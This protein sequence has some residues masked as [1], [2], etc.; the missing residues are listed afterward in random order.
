MIS[1]RVV[2]SP[3]AIDSWNSETQEYEPNSSCKPGPTITDPLITSETIARVRGMN[4]INKSFSNRVQV[5]GTT[6][7]R[8]WVS[9][10]SIVSCTDNQIGEYRGMVKSF[11]IT[12]N[13]DSRGSSSAISSIV[14]EREKI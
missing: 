10:G 14:I 11:A 5:T 3:C 4:E 12:L 13:R 7:I 8:N 6:I 2:Q 1:I 9:P